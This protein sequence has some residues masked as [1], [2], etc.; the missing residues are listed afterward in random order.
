MFGLMTIRRHEAVVD[1]MQLDMSAKVAKIDQLVGRCTN[2]EK[3]ISEQRQEIIYLKNQLATKQEQIDAEQAQNKQLNA[4]VGKMA[5]R[6]DE[7][8]EAVDTATANYQET[9]DQ[10][11]GLRNGLENYVANLASKFE[12]LVNYA[13][14][15]LDLMTKR[16]SPTIRKRARY[17]LMEQIAHTGESIGT[18]KIKRDLGSQIMHMSFSPEKD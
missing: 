12:P 4:E 16:N 3:R 8:Q 9:A 14:S 17:D 15:Y 6:V 7:M 13:Q 1:S 10:L 5:E 2:A 11:Q 18:M